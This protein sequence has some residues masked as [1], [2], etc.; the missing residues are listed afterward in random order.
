MLVTD[1]LR[2]V[3][4]FVGRKG[5]R[6]NFIAD[7]TG[8]IFLLIVHGFAFPCVVTAKH[9]VDQAAGEDGKRDVLLR[10]NT[11]DGGVDYIKT[12]LSKWQTHP[13]HVEGG[14][15]HKYI[16]VAVL[17]LIDFT[18]WA[19]T[20]FFKKFDFVHLDEDDICTEPTIQKY[21]I[22]IGDEVVIPGLFHSHI[23]T[24]QNVPIIRTG[25]I[26]AMRG[27]PV[28]TSR[29]PMDAYLVEMRSVGGISGSPVLTN[30]AIRP[31]LL[32]PESDKSKRIE[33]SSKTH[34]LLGLIHGHYTITAQDEWAFK[35]DKQVGDINAGIAI[36][37]P[38]ERIM[39]TIM[40]S[41]LFSEEFENMR[42]H[43]ESQ[44]E[45]VKTVED[46]VPASVLPASDANPHHREDFMSLLN[47]AAKTKPQAD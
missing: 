4:V 24:V 2:K 36:I 45:M 20:E 31:N 17:G 21:A 22:G 8:F 46:S 14:R 15:K 35:T 44:N 37:V 1:L 29:G 18:G 28:P 27:E 30:M 40:G 19:S 38:A 26:A 3:V 16:D 42:Q 25:N 11:K 9:V 5:E 6:E 39:E 7:G 32:L 43:R 47:A 13:D 41:K 12:T 10:L 33:Q 23:G 34:Y